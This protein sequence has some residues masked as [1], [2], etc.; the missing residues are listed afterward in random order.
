MKY[1]SW[2]KFLTMTIALFLTSHACMGQESFEW[3]GEYLCQD[4]LGKS[5]G[6]SPIVIDMNLRIK[7]D[8]S[9]SLVVNG[10][11]ISEK[12]ICR[13]VSDSVGKQI[14][15]VSYDNGKIENEYGAQQYQ[16]DEVLFSLE[17]SQDKVLTTW[18]SLKPDNIEKTK[19]CFFVKAEMVK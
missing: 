19:G 17:R 18:Q 7:A 15:F 6:G 2:A 11:Q 3:E 4:Q 5:F 1:L 8:G 14:A 13:A 16:V 9:C 12:I 10:Y